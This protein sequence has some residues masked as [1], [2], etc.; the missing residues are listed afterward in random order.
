[1]NTNELVLVQG[2]DATKATL[3]RWNADPWP[4]LRGWVGWSL[5]TAV[6]LLGAVWV[7]AHAS[8]PDATPLALPGVN[9]GVSA[10]DVVHI[11]LRNGLVLALH[12]MAC[13]AG[14]IAGSSLPQQA[15]ARTGLSRKVHERAG[16][17][18]IAFV[19]CAT[20]FS[21][22]TQAYVL[23]HDASTLSRQFGMSPALLLVG[24]LPHAVP[25]LTALF[26]PLAA[27]VI[28]SRRQRWEE[29]LA[30]TA[31]T[32]VLA[33]PVLIAAAFVELYLSP[34]L[35]VALAGG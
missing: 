32:V 23:G 25:E 33:V 15:A 5:A 7:V 4:V 1:M 30:A 35:I 16:T 8:Q 10:G 34:R 26:L 13:V 12:A 19:V 2:M 21:L 24:L 17:L 9:T 20:A 11:L 31:V 22:C 3:R 28:A 18:A 6:T 29:L 14:F 27:W